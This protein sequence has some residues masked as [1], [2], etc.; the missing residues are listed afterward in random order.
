MKRAEV[1]DRIR[2]CG[3]AND[4]LGMIRLYTEN[5]TVGYEA[6]MKAFREG[7]SVAAKARATAGT[8][9]E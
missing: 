6:A 4:Q 1:L 3:A 9:K 8:V 2:A 5:R 7:L